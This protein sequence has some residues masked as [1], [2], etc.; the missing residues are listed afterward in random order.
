M[1]STQL[2]LNSIL[3]DV[4]KYVNQV[5]IK[6]CY[7]IESDIKNFIAQLNHHSNVKWLL[8]YLEV[9]YLIC[10]ISTNSIKALPLN[11]HKVVGKFNEP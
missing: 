6:V 9:E 4:T 8:N 3:N 7:M 10:K 2:K 5:I 11:L 1:N